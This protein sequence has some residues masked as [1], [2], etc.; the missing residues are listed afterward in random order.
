MLRIITDTV[1]DL[2]PGWQEEYQVDL[3]PVNIVIDG[4]S[5][6]QG[7][8]LTNDE[9]FHY[10]ETTGRIPGTSQ[11]SPNQFIEF[12][13]KVA[14][15]ADTVLSMH[16]TEKLSGTFR[17]AV[18]AAKELYG[19][20]NIIPYDT[21]NGTI[22]AGM[23]CREARI[24][25]RAGASIAQILERMDTIRRCM[26][27]VITVDNLKYAQM[28]GRIKFLQAALGSLLQIKPIIELRD[29]MIELTGRARSRAKS[30]EEMINVMKKKLGDQKIHAGIVHVRDP[31][32]AEQLLEMVKNSFN[33][34]ETV[35]AE[36]S[37]AL[38]AHFG[39]GGLGFAAYPAE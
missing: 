25:D 28:S 35:V 29:G 20:L 32:S 17:S 10:I 22:C 36:V 24:L 8:E 7:V 33:C 38:A 6:L 27:L 39:P 14:S 15:K 37:I 4:K 16:V 5:Y 31:R 11:P 30:L 21:T 19:E 3:I 9:F 23:M 34:V 18:A 13:R 1:C 2:V 26:Q 12:Y